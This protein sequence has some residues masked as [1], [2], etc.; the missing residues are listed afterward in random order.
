[1]SFLSGGSECATNS[2]PLAQFSKSSQI[3]TGLHESI[4]QQQQQGSLVGHPDQL[5]ETVMMNQQDMQNFN[6]FQNSQNLN[7]SHHFNF[8]P[9]ANPELQ[10]QH[11]NIQ[12]QQGSSGSLVNEFNALRINQASSPMVMG[13]TKQSGWSSEFASA[14]PAGPIQQDS[15]NIPQQQHQLPTARMMPSMMNSAFRMNMMNRP[16]IL[17][18]QPIT[19]NQQ[20]QQQSDAM[21]SKEDWE[22][23][24]K[25]IEQQDADVV[26][27]SKES[28]FDKVW[29]DI[30]GKYVTPET[31]LYET[32][33]V[34]EFKA[35]WEKDFEKYATTR[36]NYG[37]YKFESQ[38]QFSKNPSAYEIGVKL[39]ESGAKLSEAALAFEAALQED[40]NHVDAWLKLG[41]VQTQN[42][43]EL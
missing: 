26:L 38:N 24:F 37:E 6:E 31:D 19:E 2:N 12:P 32:E 1:M 15:S 43:K 39:M 25:E 35:Q 8:Q 42:E 4:R 28:V 17:Q 20:V 7:R 9:M 14:G 22:E 30:E 34:N 11:L 21:L 23:T 5:R 36:L 33:D 18:A 29:D 13:S 27:N 3:D 10:A 16:N 41:Q 40:P